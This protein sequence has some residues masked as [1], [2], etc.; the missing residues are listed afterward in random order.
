MG[1]SFLKPSATNNETTAKILMVVI[2]A[3]II[4]SLL[5]KAASYAKK[6]GGAFGEMIM[7]GGAMVG[8]LALGA[9][10]GGA[11][12][13]LSNTVGRKARNVANDDELRI[14]AA[15]GDKG[16]QRKLA[17]ANSL[18]KNSFD[19]RQTGLGKFTQKQTGMNFDRGLGMVGM[20]TEKLKGGRAQR[21]K[22]KYEKGEE[23]KKSYELSPAAARAQDEKAKRENEPKDKQNARAAQYEADKEQAR[24]HL[25]GFKGDQEKYFKEAYEHGDTEFLKA[26][27]GI[28]RKNIDAGSVER[29]ESPR[30]LNAEQTNLQRREAYIL[31]LENP[32]KK[33]EK[34]QAIKKGWRDYKDEIL[35]GSLSGTGKGTIATGAVVGM[36][37]GGP[38]GA[39][40]GAA[41]AIPLG[42]LAG[43]IKDILKAQ[44]QASIS[45]LAEDKNLIAKLAKGKSSEEKILEA[46]KGRVEPGKEK[47][48]AHGITETIR[49]KTEMT[50]KKDTDTTPPSR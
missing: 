32:N 46:L 31:S 5:L 26:Q 29:D 17:L 23:I 47:E 49:P 44:A 8:G 10:T 11:A 7:K 4:L 43:T 3:V 20:S 35:R 21:D 12:F 25:G 22:E 41:L 48:V 34:G 42:G 9:A 1:P 33:I 40:I 45:F 24:Q 36:A 39:A 28:T 18:A 38:I 6:G 37:M 16:A 14:K 27:A 13:A 30:T 50:E 2:P 15:S 19:F